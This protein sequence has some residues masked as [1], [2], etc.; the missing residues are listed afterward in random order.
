MTIDQIKKELRHSFE[1]EIEDPRLKTILEY[2]EKLN[3]IKS[4][5]GKYS[6]SDAS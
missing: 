6:P 2:M 5:D 4:H 1:L 3:K